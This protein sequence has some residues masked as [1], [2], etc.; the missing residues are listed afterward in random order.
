MAASQ[1]MAASHFV[2]KENET[3]SLAQPLVCEGSQNT[4]QAPYKRLL[5]KIKW[6]KK[7]GPPAL[8]RRIQWGVQPPWN[9][10]QSPMMSCRPQVKTAEDIAQA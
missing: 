8:C 9:N 7:H 2:G 10:L 1:A 6:W 4:C 3:V 5:L